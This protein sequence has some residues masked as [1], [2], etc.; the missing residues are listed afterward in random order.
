M[1]LARLVGVLIVFVTIENKVV[2]AD[3]TLAH[4]A[5]SVLDP[6]VGSAV[7][8]RSLTCVSDV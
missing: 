7:I 2:I 3:L 6:V 8:V 1:T 5:A 4:D